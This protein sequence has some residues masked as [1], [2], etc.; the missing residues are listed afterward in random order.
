[1]K[2]TPSPCTEDAWD[3]AKAALDLKVNCAP[4]P[5]ARRRGMVAGEEGIEPSLTRV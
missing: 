4:R 3:R 1:M 5:N 2:H